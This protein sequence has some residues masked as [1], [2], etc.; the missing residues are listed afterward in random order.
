MK[1][2][3]QVHRKI[4]AITLTS[5]L[6]VINIYSQ[7]KIPYLKKQGT[8]TQ[9]IVEGKPFLILG[10]ELNNSS[11]S[12]L[13]YMNPILAK[14]SAGNLNTAL[15]AV[16]WDLIKPQE[17]K[18]DFSMVDGAIAAARQNKMHLIFL[19]FGSWKNGVSTY[20]PA[21]V[22][23]DLGRLRSDYYMIQRVKLYRYS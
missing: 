13:D 9:L 22:K 5:L 11:S 18:F 23:T 6:L 17:G 7:S 8:A 10:G 16:C 3:N 19:W 20:P 4:T 1:G 21:W 14:F 2:L 12:S 15:A